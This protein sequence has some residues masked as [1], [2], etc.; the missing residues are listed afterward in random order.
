MRY[1]HV[2]LTGS[3]APIVMHLIGAPGKQVHG[4][5]SR[6]ILVNMPR[7]N[8][9]SVRGM[10]VRRIPFFLFLLVAW[11]QAAGACTEP[12][13]A[14]AQAQKAMELVIQAV[15]EDVAPIGGEHRCECPAMVQ[16]VVSTASESN[17]FLLASYLE[18]AG[19]LQPS[20][21]P[22][23]LTLAAR[24]RAASFLARL[25]AQP[26]YLLVLHLRQ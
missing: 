1:R 22:D 25:A 26:P 23:S 16:N 14:P 5:D 17:R 12:R 9:R 21:N 4:L 24:T 20:S 6:L 3:A 8:E 18:S 19:A 7:G 10:I 15:A 11:V 2:S 13:A